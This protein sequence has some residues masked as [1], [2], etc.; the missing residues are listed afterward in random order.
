MI[1]FK[2]WKVTLHICPKYVLQHNYA[3]ADMINY[4][5]YN[6]IRDVLIFTI[7]RE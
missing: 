6:N 4:R 3:A 7:F 1:N 5:K 2:I